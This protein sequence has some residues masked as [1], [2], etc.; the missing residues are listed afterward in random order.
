MVSKTEKALGVRVGRD[1]TIP[2]TIGVEGKEF[3]Y[4]GDT[5]TGSFRD[6]FNAL[7]QFVTPPRA[8]RGGA[9]NQGC[10]LECP[11]GSIFHGIAYHGDLQGWRLQIEEGARGL[12]VPLAR[13][14]GERL[15]VSDGRSLALAECKATLT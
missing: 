9:S 8:K 10:T 13:I 15:V 7:V 4:F 3:V 5:G 1:G 2:G 11:D 6:Q 14:V 12:G